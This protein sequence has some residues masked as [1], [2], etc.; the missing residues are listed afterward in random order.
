MVGR[1]MMVSGGQPTLVISTKVRSII[2]LINCV[3]LGPKP[4][5]ATADD[6]SRCTTVSNPQ[7]STSPLFQL[8]P[9]SIAS[10]I[11]ALNIGNSSHSYGPLKTY[12]ETLL[13]WK[14]TSSIYLRTISPSRPSKYVKSISKRGI[15]D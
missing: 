7:H 15:V 10:F 5:I 12:D 3:F 1:H 13:L 11:R 14:T 4:W 2:R 8:L 9:C 6:A